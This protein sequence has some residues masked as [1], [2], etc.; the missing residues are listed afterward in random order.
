MFVSA[1]ASVQTPAILFPETTAVIGAP[2]SGRSPVPGAVTVVNDA[3][4]V[5]VTV[6]I[7]DI[8]LRLTA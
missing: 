5:I 4:P 6:P 1:I 7:L 3:F 8:V 2:G